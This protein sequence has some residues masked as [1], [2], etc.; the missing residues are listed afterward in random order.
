MRQRQ[1]GQRLAADLGGGEVHGEARR[2]CAGEDGV[3][4]RR[5]DR[6]AQLLADGGGRDSASCGPTPNV[7][8]LIDGAITMPTPI[9]TRTS[10]PSSPSTYPVCGPSWASQRRRRRLTGDRP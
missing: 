2:G 6:S 9:A 10:G 8:V 7:P 4:Q 5:P 1:L 3:Q